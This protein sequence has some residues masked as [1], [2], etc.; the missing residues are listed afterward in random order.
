M[1]WVVLPLE[2][3]AGSVKPLSSVLQ[4]LAPIALKFL[5]PLPF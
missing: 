1:A 5:M 3:V 4:S 2:G